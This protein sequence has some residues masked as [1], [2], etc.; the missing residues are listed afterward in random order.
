MGTDIGA[1]VALDTLRSVPVRNL[2]RDAPLLPGT[3]LAG[4]RTVGVWYEIG[5]G[6]PVAVHAVDRFENLLDEVRLRYGSISCVTYD[7][8]LPGFWNLDLDDIRDT[9]LDRPVVHL[10]DGFALLAIALERSGLHVFDRLVH[11]DDSGD[12]EERG[13][14]DRVCPAAQTKLACDLLAVDDIESDVLVGQRLLHSIRQTTFNLVTPPVGGQQKASAV[15]EIA[16]QVVPADVGLVVACHEV[17]LLD[18]I[19]SPYRRRSE[20]QMASGD[21][22]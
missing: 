2:H 22:A 4:E 7:D 19:G 17:G 6:N 14:Q 15:L 18:Q 8:V 5:Y 21:A 10:D 20:P 12:L 1:L 16:H 11:G 3:G 9:A 13:L